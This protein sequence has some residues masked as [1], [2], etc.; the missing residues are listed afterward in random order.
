MN[1]IS[2]RQRRTSFVM[3]AT[4]LLFTFLL[5]GLSVF[6][7]KGN[8]F[9][10]VSFSE[11]LVKLYSEWLYELMT[12][13]YDLHQPVMATLIEDSESEIENE[14]KNE[15]VQALSTQS[16]QKAENN[17]SEGSEGFVYNPE[18]PMPKE[19]QS[20]L[21]KLSKERQIDYAIALAIIKHESGFDPNKISKTNDYGYFQINKIN[22]ESLAKTLNTPNDPLDPYIN[23]NW[24]TYMLGQLY[25][26]WSKEY[27]G[28]Q[29][30]EIVW[31]CYNLGEFGYKKHGIATKYVKKVNL[32]LEEIKEIL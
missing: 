18:I 5:V 23:I 25:S 7:S 19:H 31:S 32:A 21:Y 8:A 29:L 2:S 30:H 15:T 14:A 12:E 17:S 13:R 20:Y 11:M 28:K 4:I 9:F 1:R 26:K 16:V 24:G 22:H 10:K 27:A 3:L 6:P